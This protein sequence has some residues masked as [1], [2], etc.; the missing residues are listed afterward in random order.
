MARERS[1]L[2]NKAKELYINSKGT[3]KLVDIAAQ[4]DIKDSQVRKW[5]SQD[6]WDN[7]LGTSKGALP[8]KKVQSKSNVTNKK[9]TIKQNKKIIKEPIADEIK[10]VL[11][12]TELNDKQRLFCVIYAKCFNATKAYQKVYK[13]TYETAMA[14]G[15]N[16][17]RN[18][19]IKEQIDSLTAIQFNKEAL[20]RSVIQKYI[21]IAFADI[22]DYVKFG[23]KYRAVWTKDKEGRDV[24][25][26]DPNTGEQKIKE[27]N[28]LDLKESSLVDTTLINEVAEGKDG[29]KF[30][31][32]DKMKALDFLTKHCNLLSDEEKTKLQIENMRYQNT[33]LQAETE[34]IK[35]KDK[36]EQINIVIKRKER[37]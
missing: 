35:G 19:K 3:M 26:I 29:I 28:Y 15:S 4:L 14:N 12:N 30:K 18:T 27:Y 8:N 22:G 2:R 24:P 1:P 17:L 9:V 37:D 32:A 21:D 23:K 10:E 34:K 5:K 16:L 33:K 31:L 6:K 25:V 20:K 11:E 7:E 13:C 36:D